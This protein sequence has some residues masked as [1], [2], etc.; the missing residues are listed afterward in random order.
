MSKTAI[1]TA[2]TSPVSITLTT[3]Q[4]TSTL[5][6]GTTVRRFGRL[7]CENILELSGTGILSRDS[8]YYQVDASVVMTPSAA[9]DYTVALYQDGMPVQ[10]ASQTV[11]AA[12]AA[13]IS[14]TIPAIVRNRCDCG[15]STLTL[16]VSTAA[17]L[18]ATIIVNNTGVTVEKI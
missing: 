15:A 12:A 11:T 3:A 13:V 1:Y 5:P 14:F 6:L 8:G 7:N 10:G 18:P 4:P 17:A 16:V 2:S 9:G